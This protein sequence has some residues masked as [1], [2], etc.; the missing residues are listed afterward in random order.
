MHNRGLDARILSFELKF[1]D[2]HEHSDKIHDFCG[3][4]YG[5]LGKVLS[6]YLLA[7]DHEE[8][9][10]KYE[11]C[12]DDMRDAIDDVPS[13]DLAQRLINEYAVILLAGKVLAEH[14]VNIDIDGITAIMAD[15]CKSIRES[16]DIAGKYYHHLVNYAVMYPYG[17]GIKKDE[18]TNSVAFIDEFFLGI[19][20]DYG[21]SN[22][23]LVIKELDAAGYLFRRKKNSLKNRL[24]F[25]GTLA[26]CY[27]IVLPK[28]DSD[29][30]DDYMTLESI[31]TYFEGV[32]ES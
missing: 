11:E 3:K 6:E 5:V 21:A 26:N 31:L 1:T 20:N 9:A 30:D 28:D 14:G 25:N 18:R 4:Q 24:R 29:L 15:N 2:S 10:R 19:L 7:V 13:F 32:D 22:P 23:D 8:I 27:E 12:R 16:T 17:E